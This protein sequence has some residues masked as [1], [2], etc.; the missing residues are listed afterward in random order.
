MTTPIGVAGY[1]G[2]VKVGTSAS[3]TNSLALA[4]DAGVPMTTGM[5]DTTSLGGTGWNTFIPGLSGSKPT[6]KYAYDL[7]DTTGQLV[8]QNAFIN[9]TLLYWI[10]SPDNTHTVSFTAYV[11]SYQLGVPVNNLVSGQVTLQMTGAPTLA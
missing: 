6:L 3:P 8:I 10:V 5:Y 4:N 1:T 7:N 2:Y 11:E 9:K